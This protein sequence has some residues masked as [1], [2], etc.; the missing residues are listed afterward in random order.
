[1]LFHS[2]TR[3][4]MINIEKFHKNKTHSYSTIIDMFF[5]LFPRD[6]PVTIWSILR[7]FGA[8]HKTL[9]SS[10]TSHRN[11]RRQILDRETR[12]KRGDNIYHHNSMCT[13]CYLYL[14]KWPG[15]VRF[16]PY[17][18]EIDVNNIYSCACNKRFYNVFGDFPVH[19]E[20]D[21]FRISSDL[22]HCMQDIPVINH[23]QCAAICFHHG[24]YCGRQIYLHMPSICPYYDC[25]AC[26]IHSLY[27]R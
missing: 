11:I 6:S 19:S 12:F 18:C 15:L 5:R 17:S 10:W 1:M 8:Q 4:H 21:I 26:K 24:W 22:W 7:V 23:V 16:Q 20:C 14:G 2:Q 3:C 27:S 9:T 13:K 25:A